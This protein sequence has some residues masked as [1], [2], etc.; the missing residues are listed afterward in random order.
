MTQSHTTATLELPAME[1]SGL[2]VEN[3][4]L[5]TAHDRFLDTSTSA[6]LDRWTDL[7]R[8]QVACLAPAE[9]DYLASR[10]QW[11]TAMSVLDI[12]CGD[13]S[14]VRA[15]RRANPEK[16]FAG[17]DISEG[18][19]ARARVTEP[20]ADFEVADLYTYAPEATFDV[21][22]MRFVVQHLTDFGGVLA[23]CRRLLTPGGT[24]LII[25]PDLRA[26]YALPPM[27]AV[28]TLFAAFET[29]RAENQRLRDGINDPQ[30]LLNGFPDWSVSFDDQVPVTVSGPQAAD[31]FRHWLGAIEDSGIVDGDYGKAE[32]ELSRLSDGDGR[33][34]VVLRIIGIAAL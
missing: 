2:A 26:S 27:P 20:A 34:T 9:I 24:V 15:L 13:G 16:R 3:G 33:A 6:L 19:L 11:Q 31:L 7:L 8:L 5:T 21:V 18:L 30:R 28:E 14:F 4:A 23:C 17:I 25:E 1:A 32:R 12:G 10:R 29:S 22:V